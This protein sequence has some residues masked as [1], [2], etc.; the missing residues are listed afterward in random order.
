MHMQAVLNILLLVLIHINFFLG[1]MQ[2]LMNVLKDLQIAVTFVTTL[3]VITT[4]A[5]PSQVIGSRVTIS[6]VRVCFFL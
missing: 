2:T 1:N 4:V 5:A 6:P 3:L